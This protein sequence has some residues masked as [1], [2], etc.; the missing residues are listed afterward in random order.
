MI[1]SFHPVFDADQQ[2]ILGSRSLN[3]EDMGFIRKAKVIL[4]PQTCNYTLY[5]A[6]QGSS[7]YIFPNYEIRFK[8]SGKMGQSLLFKEMELPSP[9]THEWTAVPQFEDYIKEKDSLPHNMPFFLKTNRGHEAE[10]IFLIENQKTLKKGLKHFQILEQSGTFGFISQ[11]F[12]QTQGNVLRSVILNQTILTYWKRPPIPNQKITSINRGALIDSEWREDLQE[13]GKQATERLIQ[14]TGIN[15]AA[16]D[17]V[18]DLT[19]HNPDPLF[20]EINY[21]FGRRGLGGSEN[22][23]RLLYKAIIEWLKG[24][25]LDPESVRLT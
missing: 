14:K 1:L 23:Y 7:A 21:S 17:I 9:M 22:F 25:G 20:L 2:I 18:F 10:G 4:L 24:K 3:E 15:L 19:R 13:K 8:Y 16:V 12:I 6:C 5:K 11:E